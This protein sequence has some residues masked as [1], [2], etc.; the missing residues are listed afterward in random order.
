LRRQS[1]RAPDPERER[2]EIA[3]GRGPGLERRDPAQQIAF[4]EIECHSVHGAVAGE[5]DQLAHH[6]DVAARILHPEPDGETETRRRRRVQDDEPI[7]EPDV[8][9]PRAPILSGQYRA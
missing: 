2:R 5:V 1:R 9:E 6:A 7:V 3:E 8:R 4:H